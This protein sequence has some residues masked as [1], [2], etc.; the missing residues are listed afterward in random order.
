[1]PTSSDIILDIRGLSVRFDTD[2]GALTVVENVSLCLPRGAVVG[3][4]GES[5]CGKSVTAL[6]V[7]RLLPAPAGRVTAGEIWFEGEDL[8]RTP[9]DRLRRVRGQRIAMVFQE[10]MT[11]LSPLHT[12]GDQLAETWR[13]HRSASRAEARTEALKWLR[14]VGLPDPE[15]RLDARPHQLSGGMLQRVMLAMAM[16]LHPALL[17]ADEP[18]TALDVTIQ[19]QILDLMRQMKERDTAILLITHDLGVIWEMC[20]TVAVM[21]AGR[22]VE[23]APVNALFQAPAHPYTRGLLDAVLSLGAPARRLKDIPG[24]V[25]TAGQYPPGCRF[26]PRCPFAFDRCRVEKPPLQD[27]GNGQAAA[28]FLAGQWAGNRSGDPP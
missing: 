4:V 10:P 24:Q 13:L 15:E 5:G 3:L 7:L 27:V 23:T 26:H 18:T 25:P 12:I 2:D 16:M 21:Y 6:S 22:V 28:C 19:A 20:D 8:L 9:P 11:A 1:M 17:I 14:R